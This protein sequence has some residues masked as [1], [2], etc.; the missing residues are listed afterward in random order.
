MRKLTQIWGSC[1]S[2][3]SVIEVAP[4]RARIV[5]GW[6]TVLA[7]YQPARLIQPGLPSAARR[8]RTN[9]NWEGIRRSG[10]RSGHASDTVVYPPTGSTAD[11]HPPTS[12]PIAIRR[13]YLHID[14]T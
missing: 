8:K 4:R 14:N 2:L 9:V 1:S 11:M 5:L 3:I 6:A 12:K 13:D 7:C 10:G